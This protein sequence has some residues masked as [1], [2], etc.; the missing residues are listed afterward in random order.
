MPNLD[1]LRRDIR[2]FK[3]NLRG[4]PD[5]YGEIRWY[6]NIRITAYNNPANL[7]TSS[8]I[9]LGQR[10]FSLSDYGFSEDNLV[11]MSRIINELLRPNVQKGNLV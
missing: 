8:K 1:K 7:E 3:E 6:C 9:L 2:E 11:E 10:D 4:T 5:S